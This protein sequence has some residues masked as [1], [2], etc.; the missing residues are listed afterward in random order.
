VPG[1]RPTGD[2]KVDVT[3]PRLVQSLTHLGERFNIDAVPIELGEVRGDRERDGVIGAN[4]DP[5]AGR[6]TP[7]RLGEDEVFVVLRIAVAEAN[8]RIRTR[9]KDRGILM[10]NGE[11]AIA[12]PNHEQ[13]EKN[14][15]KVGKSLRTV[16]CLD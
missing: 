16:N 13:K 14:K 10:G 9:Q 11:S 1:L 8:T 7:K 15:A 6:D 3:R 4:I 12:Q 5:K 2:A